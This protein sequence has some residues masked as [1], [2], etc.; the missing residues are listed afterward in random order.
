MLNNEDTSLLS[1]G[2]IVL[3]LL[4]KGPTLARYLREHGGQLELELSN[5]SRVQLPYERVLLSLGSNIEVPENLKALN[6]DLGSLANKFN[7]QETWEKLKDG[8]RQLSVEQIAHTYFG[9]LPSSRELIAIVMHLETSCIYFDRNDSFYCPAYPMQIEKTLA[10]IKSLK[11]KKQALQSLVKSLQERKLPEP[12]TL[13][14]ENL[15]KHVR[16]FAIHGSSYPGCKAALDVLRI[17]E[18]GSKNKQKKAWELL[19]S[20]NLASKDEPIELEREGIPVDFCIDTV[21]QAES[22]QFSNFDKEDRRDLTNIFTITVDNK[23]TKDR[24]DA[25]SIEIQEPDVVLLGVHITDVASIIPKDSPIDLEAASRNTSIYMPDLTINMLPDTLSEGVLSLSEN[26]TSPALT[27]MSKFVSGHLESWDIFTSYIKPDKVMTYEQV[28]RVLLSPGEAYYVELTAFQDITKS[29]RSLRRESGAVLLNRP[30]LN[31][32]VIPDNPVLIEVEPTD[33]PGRLA[34]AE[35]MVLANSLLAKLCTQTNLP[36][37]YRAQG[38]A[39]VEAYET[40]LPNSSDILGQYELM[41]K[42]PPAYMTTV[43]SGHSGIGVEHYVQMTAPI[44]RFCDLVMQRQVSH[45]LKYGSNLYSTAELKSIVQCSVTKLKRASSIANGRNRYWFLK[46][47]ENQLDDGI[48]EYQAV[49]LTANWN[50]YGTLELA[51]Y[52]FRFKALLS[53]F[54][55]PG[56]FISLS[57]SAVDMWSRTPKFNVIS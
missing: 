53:A 54:H 2:E 31:I 27:I 24:D 3:I 7:L 6:K 1:V 37:I 5:K 39:D 21:S 41:R 9:H 18:K 47:L 48:D 19:V 34:V 14:H 55:R 20:V 33:T 11:G 50:G 46:W 40:F 13:E 49:V 12:L 22:I 10:D 4:N 56:D 8:A 30:S 42:L 51:E 32:T 23:H 52:P 25:I 28:D 35:A 43:N 29:L 38:K 57:L 45:M 44:R 26:E 16:E 36:T 15:L 17:I